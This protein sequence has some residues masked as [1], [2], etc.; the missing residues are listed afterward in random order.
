MTSVIWIIN[1]VVL[2][3]FR[4]DQ[5]LDINC[6]LS[7]VSIVIYVLYFCYIG[8]ADKDRSL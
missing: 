1:D 2:L 3:L 5:Y 7:K 8:K 4:F 6:P